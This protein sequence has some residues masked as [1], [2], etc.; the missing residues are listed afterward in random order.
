MRVRQT[1]DTGAGESSHRRARARPSAN[2]AGATFPAVVFTGRYNGGEPGQPAARPRCCSA[3]Q[4][5]G[6][7]PGTS[8]GIADDTQLPPPIENYGALTASQ[9][10]GLRPQ[11]RHV[12]STGQHRPTQSAT[13]CSYT[14]VKVLPRVARSAPRAPRRPE[15]DGFRL[16]RHRTT[17]RPAGHHGRHRST[18]RHAVFT[19][20]G[21][22]TAQGESAHGFKRDPGGHAGGAGQDSAPHSAGQDFPSPEPSGEPRQS[23]KQVR[24]TDG[25]LRVFVGPDRGHGGTARATVPPVQRAHSP[26]ASRTLDPLQPAQVVLPQARPS[27]SRLREPTRWIARDTKSAT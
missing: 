20:P 14:C 6:R 3:K 9:T 7:A 27:R 26:R 5:P 2:A 22:R 25:A 4:E 21:N 18:R 11:N 10:G 12:T 17:A 23:L 1:P 15:H 19:V 16:G 24:F 8:P 13:G